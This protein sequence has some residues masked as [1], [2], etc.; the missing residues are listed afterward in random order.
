MT[1]CTGGSACRSRRSR[2]ARKQANAA[3][4]QF[5]GLVSHELRT[6]LTTIRGNADVLVREHERLDPETRQQALADIASESERLQRIVDNLLLL[7]RL[8]QGETPEAEP[9]LVIREINK[10]VSRHQRQHPDRKF[11]VHARHK[12]R[13]VLFSAT[14]LDQVLD[15]LL[16]NAEKYSPPGEPIEI[17]IDR[18]PDRVVVRVVDRGPGIDESEQDRVFD[19]FYRGNAARDSTMGIGIGLSV[20]KRL[21]ESQGG[22]IRARNRAGSG[23]EFEFSLPVVRAR[24]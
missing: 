19:P 13:P 2:A 15:N 16:S 1:A 22:E 18:T 11:Q 23:A 9:V 4:D 24:V 3:K 21:V 17:E 20:C 8:E 14:Y 5:L 7:A 10:V 12:P 6:P